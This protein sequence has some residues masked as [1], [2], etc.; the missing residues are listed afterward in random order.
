[1][2]WA[3]NKTPSISEFPTLGD[4]DKAMIAAKWTLAKVMDRNL[5]ACRQYE[6]ETKFGTLKVFFADKYLDMCYWPK[7][8]N[9]TVAARSVRYSPR[10]KMIM[11]N[12]KIFEKVLLADA[13]KN[14]L[15]THKT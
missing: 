5:P 8:N 4:I 2:E 7:L 12:V 11:R 15:T 6:K 13:K 9:R 1:M 10:I 3:I 14:Y